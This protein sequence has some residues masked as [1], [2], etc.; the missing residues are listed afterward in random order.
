M[1]SAKSDTR[2]KESKDLREGDVL[3][4]RGD[5]ALTKPVGEGHY[6]KA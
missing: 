4:Q 1:L 2:L 5:G 3:H 6:A